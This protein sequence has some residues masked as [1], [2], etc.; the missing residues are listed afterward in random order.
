MR[1]DY[2]LMIGMIGMRNEGRI[3]GI[4]INKPEDMTAFHAKRRL[5]CSIDARIYK[6]IFF[7]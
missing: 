3:N 6:Q 1:I 4:E 7:L 2:V 5:H